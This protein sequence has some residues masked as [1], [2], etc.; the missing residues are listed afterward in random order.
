MRTFIS[1]F[2]GEGTVASQR[3]VGHTVFPQQV[4]LTVRFGGEKGVTL[5]TRERFLA[6]RET[7]DSGEEG[8]G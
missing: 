3:P 7:K 4:A 6:W 1:V 8:R 5:G 2:L